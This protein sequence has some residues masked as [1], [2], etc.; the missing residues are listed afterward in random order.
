MCNVENRFLT[1]SGLNKCKMRPIKATPSPLRSKTVSLN[2]CDLRI[3]IF[4][5]SIYPLYLSQF[6]V[7]LFTGIDAE[8]LSLSETELWTELRCLFIDLPAAAELL[9]VN[10]RNLSPLHSRVRARDQSSTIGLKNSKH[11]GKT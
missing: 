1:F 4:V 3:L 7:Y 5:L 6:C 2:I 10:S 9:K 11:G 8:G